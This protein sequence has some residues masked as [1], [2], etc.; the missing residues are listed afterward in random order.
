M[1]YYTQPIKLPKTAR[2]ALA[3]ALQRII[4]LL[5]AEDQREA[6]LMTVD[7]W[8]DVDCG[9]WDD[10][11]SDTKAWDAVI[12]SARQTHA[13]EIAAA[14]D[15]GVAQGAYDAKARIAKVLGLAA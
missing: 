15:R 6:L 7:L 12:E 2:D 10:A 11:M 3:N 8:H 1:T 14:Y 4:N 13:A 5:E 9:H